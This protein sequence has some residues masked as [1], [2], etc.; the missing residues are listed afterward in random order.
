MNLETHHNVTL[1]TPLNRVNLW[2]SSHI[3][4]TLIINFYSRGMSDL[5]LEVIHPGKCATYTKGIHRAYTPPL[6]AINIRI[7]LDTPYKIP[8]ISDQWKVLNWGNKCSRGGKVDLDTVLRL[9]ES[10]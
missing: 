2:H 4:I 9:N 6:Y 3:C 10:R 8:A 5:L 1:S 7:L